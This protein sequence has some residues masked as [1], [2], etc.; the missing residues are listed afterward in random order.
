MK[1]NPAVAN[2]GGA[3][4]FDSHIKDIEFELEVEFTLQSEL[5]KARGFMILLTQ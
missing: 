4:L 1:V 3:Y 5:D 2:R